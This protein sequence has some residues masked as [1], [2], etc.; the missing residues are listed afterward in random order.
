[1]IEYFIVIAPALAE[2]LVNTLLFT[3]VGMVVGFFFAVPLCLVDLYTHGIWKKIVHVYVEIIRG[4]PLLVQLYI[5]YYGLPKILLPMGLSISSFTAAYIG[6]ILN[7]AAYQIEYMKGGFKAI[8]NEQI[9]AAHSLGMSK[10]Q[11]I[12]TI[13]LPQGL[14]FSIPALSNELIY[15]LKY[16]SLGFVIQAPE[17]MTKAKELAST[18]AKYMETY[19]I[20]AFIYVGF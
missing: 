2:G 9:E 3:F 20:V 16:T 15:L 17:L 4:T 7:S 18:H 19:L 11:T 10:V 13:L 5:L 14:R 12:I 6:F 1:M 8:S